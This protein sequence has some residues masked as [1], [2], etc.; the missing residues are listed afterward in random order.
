MENMLTFMGSQ[1]EY[2]ARNKVVDVWSF[3]DHAPH[4]RCYWKDTILSLT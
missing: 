2:K 3:L 1:R 4:Y